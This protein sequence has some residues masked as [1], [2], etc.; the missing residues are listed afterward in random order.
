MISAMKP[1]RSELAR[2]ASY[3][4]FHYRKAASYEGA[5]RRTSGQRDRQIQASPT[6]RPD[7]PGGQGPWYPRYPCLGRGTHGTGAPERLEAE[8]E[9]ARI[10]SM[11]RWLG[12]ATEVRARYNEEAMR[13]SSVIFVILGEADFNRL[14]ESGARHLGR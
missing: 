10:P 8:K 14:R 7:Q 4:F 3:T 1:Q 6:W 12:W 13:A 5:V 11:V 9:G 2:D